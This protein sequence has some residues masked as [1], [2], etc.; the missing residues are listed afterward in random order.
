[1]KKLIIFIIITLITS[2]SFAQLTPGIYKFAKITVDGSGNISAIDSLG[3]VDPTLPPEVRD[4]SNS[5][6]DRWNNAYIAFTW[7]APQGVFL[8]LASSYNNPQF[9]TGIATSRIAWPSDASH[10][11]DGAGGIQA[12]PQRSVSNS[13]SRSLNSSFQPSTTHDTFVSY[14]VQI[15]CTLSLTTGQTGT[16]SIQTSPNNST[17]TEIGKFVNTNTGSLVIGL[18]LTNTNTGQLTAYVPSGYYVKLVSSGTGIS[19]YITG[20]ELAY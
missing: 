5:D 14:S 13:S 19:T 9:L 7:G 10:Y 8:S 17:W 1:M 11:I 16:I 2:V 3:E 6:Q 18:S 4:I 15:A 12:F 20:Q